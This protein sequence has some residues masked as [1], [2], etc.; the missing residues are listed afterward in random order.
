MEEVWKPV[1][2][3]EDLYEV[4]NYGNVRRKIKLRWQFNKF[5]YARV[6][7]WRNGV[8]KWKMIHRLVADAFLPNPKNHPEINH[9]DENKLNNFVFVNQYGSVDPEKSNIEW[10]THEYNNNYGTRIERCLETRKENKTSCKPIKMLSLNNELIKMF[11][12]ATEA[13]VFVGAKTVSNISGCAN[14][15]PH[16]NTAY[17]YKWEWA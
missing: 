15:K 11:E 14:H 17:G 5:G 7:L 3:Y 12:S 4:S 1:V 9:K 6:S 16:H 10:C 8:Q 13:S 2:G